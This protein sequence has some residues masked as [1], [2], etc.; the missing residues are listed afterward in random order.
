MSAKIL[1]QVFDRAVEGNTQLVLLALADHAEHDG[2]QVRPGVARIAWKTGLSE[3]TVRGIVGRLRRDGVLVTVRTGGGSGHPT[4]YRLDLDALPLKRSFDE[5]LAEWHAR[6]A[7]TERRRVG[8]MGAEAAPIAPMGADARGNG[9]P[10]AA[11][12]PSPEPSGV[13]PPSEGADAPTGAHLIVQAYVEGRASAGLIPCDANGRR[14]LGAHAKTYL[15]RPIDARVARLPGHDAVAWR[16]RLLSEAV[17]AARVA[18]E[19][20]RN[21]GFLCDWLR[22][23]DL[24]EHQQRKASEASSPRRNGLRPLR[25]AS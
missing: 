6:D 3:R 19:Q 25:V 10:A 15:T 14:I 24:R 20:G 23:R 17:A 5:F 12:D 8:Q 11:P 18:G 4:E 16:E 2:T 13:R 22:E 9:A 21:P 1:G 7:A